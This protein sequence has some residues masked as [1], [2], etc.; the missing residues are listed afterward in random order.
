MGAEMTPAIG[1][2]TWASFA[3][4]ADAAHVAG[5]VAMLDYEVNPVIAALRN[6]GLEV[7]ALHH[8]MIGDDPHMIFLHYYGSGP[9]A[10]LASGFRAAL[11]CL[12]KGKPKM[13]M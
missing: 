1:L 4:T 9:A 10:T 8:H 11:D 13:K 6:N 7:V 12:G 5:D 2:N 3:G